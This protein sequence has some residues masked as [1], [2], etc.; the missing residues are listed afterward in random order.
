MISDNVVKKYVLLIE[1]HQIP[2]NFSFKETME[3]SFFFYR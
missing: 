1:T 3:F 2:Q